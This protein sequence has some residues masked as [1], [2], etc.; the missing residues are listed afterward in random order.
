MVARAE[1]YEKLGGSQAP[2]KQR[3]HKT[4]SLKSS[5]KAHGV[6]TTE[7]VRRQRMVDLGATE[8]FHWA[9]LWK[10]IQ[11][12]QRPKQKSAHALFCLVFC[13][14]CMDPWSLY[15]RSPHGERLYRL[16]GSTDFLT[17]QTILASLGAHPASWQ[18]AF[19]VPPGRH[20]SCICDWE[21]CIHCGCY[22]KRDVSGWLLA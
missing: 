22:G 6:E 9:L 18:D 1:S 4:R 7:A 5:D 10:T 12:E 20:R 15:K 3:L 16:Q 13:S 21:S 11:S 14:D 2:S 19:P 8:C 17:Y